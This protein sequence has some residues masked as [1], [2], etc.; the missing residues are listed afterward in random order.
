MRKPAATRPAL[1]PETVEA[2]RRRLEPL[3]RWRVAAGMTKEELGHRLGVSKGTVSQWFLG[4]QTM[5]PGQ[6]DKALQELGVSHFRVLMH[7]HDKLHAQNLAKLGYLVPEL[8]S[9]DLAVVIA[10]IEALLVARS[11]KKD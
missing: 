11:Q 8:T 10:T 3:D 4:R 6:F 7:P 5:P 9:S 2:N 1:P